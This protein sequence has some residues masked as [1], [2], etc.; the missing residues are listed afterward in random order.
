[1]RSA[2]LGPD[3]VTLLLALV[4]YLR[5][6]GPVP[7]PELAERFGV[8]PRLLR[9]LVRFLGTAGVPGETLSYQ[10]EDLFD[11]D[12]DALELH[13]TVS[14]T[15]T[16]AVEE[17]PRFA[18]Q[19]TAA[20]VAG[21][22]AL[23]AML[24][25][26]DAA[27]ARST[28]EKLG[29]A[30]G[31]SGFAAVSIAPST[32]QP[33]VAAIFSAI[34]SGRRLSFRYRDAAG[35]ETS[36]TVLPRLLTQGTGTWYL[37]GYCFERA[38]ERTFRLDQ[39]SGLRL[40]DTDAPAGQVRVAPWPAASASGPSIATSRE[41]A[42]SE[43]ADQEPPAI[44]IEALA[45]PQAAARLRGFAPEIVEEFD[46]G[47]LRLQ[48]AAWHP[49]AAVQVVQVLPGD[50]EIVAPASARASVA[51]WAERALASYDE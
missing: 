49:W 2:L 34:E 6:A 28:A 33:E 20:L 4:A 39:I 1:M 42:A 29:A 17:A 18:P 16:V 30:L 31:S 40:V 24:G 7:V 51:E 37:R 27:L 3:R 26:E 9:T 32:E 50:I 14:L 48:I 10:D 15:R 19:E 44:L 21:L 11:I 35:A 41:S 25:P 46:D 8:A 22:Q 23:T 38:A 43:P 45:S 5:E 36:R 12:W 47:R 13:D